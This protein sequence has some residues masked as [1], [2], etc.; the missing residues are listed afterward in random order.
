[1]ASPE[2]GTRKPKPS[3]T[4]TRGSSPKPA[5]QREMVMERIRILFNQAGESFRDHPER[6]R[7]YV[8]MALRLSTRYNV[9]FPHELKRS[10]CRKCHSFL[11]PGANAK[12]RTSPSQRAVTL[13]CMEC[14]HV[15]RHPYRKEKK[16]DN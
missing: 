14:G 6:S 2:P 3:K 12:I 10:F 16:S 5:W 7:R 8:E 4:K 15:A 1:M 13:T 11:V 9:R